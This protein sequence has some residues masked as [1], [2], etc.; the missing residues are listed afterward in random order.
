MNSSTAKVLRAGS[1]TLAGSLIGRG[2]KRADAEALLAQLIDERDKATP[3]SLAAVALTQVADCLQRCLRD[4]SI[5]AHPASSALQAAD[6]ALVAIG[7][8]EVTV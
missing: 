3:D 2:G 5:P 1:A 4:G 8:P 7:E 6:A